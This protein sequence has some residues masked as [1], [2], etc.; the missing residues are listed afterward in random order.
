MSSEIKTARQAFL[1]RRY[2]RRHLIAKYRHKAELFNMQAE[3]FPQYADW[4]KKAAKY[5][6]R[7]ANYH[8]NMLV[9]EQQEWDAGY[10]P[11]INKHWKAV[12]S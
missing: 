3:T 1:A 2:A 7:Q 6:Q 4:A 10:A 12:A 5:F 11:P 9:I 8:R